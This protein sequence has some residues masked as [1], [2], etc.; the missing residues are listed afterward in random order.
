MSNVIKI[1]HGTNPPDAGVLEE[2]ELGYSNS[3]GG[4]YLGQGENEP[5]HLNDLSGVESKIEE[6]NESIKNVSGIIVS[7]SAPDNTKVLWIDTSNPDE[8]GL[9]KYYV[10]GSEPPWVT[11]SASATATWG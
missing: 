7:D 2:Y 1:K 11:I 8:P 4:L 6:V 5:I 10:E 3:N 9:A